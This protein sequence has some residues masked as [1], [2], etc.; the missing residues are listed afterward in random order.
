MKIIDMAQ[1]DGQD[2]SSALTVQ[3]H[4]A[5]RDILII[6]RV[7]LSGLSASPTERRL[8]VQIDGAATAARAVADAAATALLLTSE[9]LPVRAGEQVTVRVSGAAG[10][11]AVDVASELLGVDAH[12]ALDRARPAAP[13]AGSLFD[14]A[15]RARARLA[16]K[17]TETIET[18]VL[19]VRDDDGEATLFTLTPTEADGV[20]GLEPGE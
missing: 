4:T 2:I 17:V 5:G 6:A 7:R 19:E 13:A 10:D 12:S 15:H 9:P 11:T 3:Q 18:R 8:V 20:I 16:N 14:D 1:A